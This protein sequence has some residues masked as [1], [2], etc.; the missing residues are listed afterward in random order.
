[1][2]E[3]ILKVKTFGN[4]SMEYNG[5]PLIKKKTGETQFTTLMQ[6]VIHERRNGVNRKYLEEILFGERKI[7]NV[8]H[9]L[10]SVIYNAKKRLEKAGLPKVN[11][12]EIKNGIVY[13]TKEIEIQEDASE[14]DFLYQKIKDEKNNERKIQYIEQIFHLYTGEFLKEKKNAVW[15]VIEA[16]HYQTRFRQCV[17]EAAD[18]YRSQQD[19]SKLEYLGKYASEIEPFLE[20]EALTMEAMVAQGRFEEAA[21]L[22]ADTADYYFEER[23]L[24]LSRK[25][26]DSLNQLGNQV[27]HSYEVLDHIQERLEEKENKKGAYLCSYPTFRGI[28]QQLTRM[29]ERSGQSIY[30]MLCTIVDSKG[31]PM[32]EG[33]LLEELAKRLEK[34]IC[35]SIRSSDVVNHYSKGQYL[36]LLINTTREDCQIV[37]ERINH[38]FLTERQRT[39][40]RY[41]VN[42][43][44]YQEED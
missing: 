43:V 1:M 32:K 31:K 18:I 23:G 9:A 16:N 36:V 30:L 28:Y 7:E 14:F 11:Y 44:W 34:A 2:K 22:Y 37:Q 40:V 5:K 26:M 10:Q 8:Q 12:I 25:L 29:L 19:Y 17:E 39:G 24:K 3:K 27:M 42:D 33:P 21:D 38:H 20:W 41:Y 15:V 35:T 13:W 6:I 4:F